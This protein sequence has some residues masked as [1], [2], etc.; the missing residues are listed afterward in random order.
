MC[1]VENTSTTFTTLSIAHDYATFL[2]VV[3]VLRFLIG[4][5]ATP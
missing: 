2:G 4:G 3:T 5:N 1:S